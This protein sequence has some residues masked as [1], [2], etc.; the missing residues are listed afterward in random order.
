MKAHLAL[1]GFMASGKSTV[2]RHVAR[3]LGLGFVD[4]D[5]AV[6]ARHGP[7]ERIFADEGEAGF[8]AHE[9]EAIREALAG[10]AAVIAT[11]GGALTHEPTRAL[12]ASRAVR[13]YL[14]VPLPTLVAR[15]RRSKTVRPMLGGAIDVDRIRA[16][17]EAR[18]PLYRQA[19]M[20]VRGGEQ[21]QQVAR[22]V[23]ALA[24]GHAAFRAKR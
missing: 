23:V 22:R 11:G 7:V 21:S 15:L 12:L 5:A 8:R 18:T 3:A 20:V 19:D 16:L 2:G 10:P 1:V 17:H 4:T 24:R 14:D 13:V 6:I 9:F